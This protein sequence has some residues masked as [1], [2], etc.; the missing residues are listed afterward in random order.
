MFSGFSMA[1][2]RRASWGDAG[3]SLKAGAA[4]RDRMEGDK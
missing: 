2:G 1:A 4:A 3:P